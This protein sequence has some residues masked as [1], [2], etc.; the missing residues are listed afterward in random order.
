LVFSEKDL[1][2]KSYCFITVKEN[3]EQQIYVIL[4]RN[5]PAFP[6][7]EMLNLANTKNP[8]KFFNLFFSKWLEK[9]NDI[10][11]YHFR[12]YK[13]NDDTYHFSSFNWDVVNYFY[14]HFNGTPLKKE[15]LSKCLSNKRS[16]KKNFIEENS[17]LI[18]KKPTKNYLDW[19]E[20]LFRDENNSFAT[21]CYSIASY[22][23]EKVHRW[24]SRF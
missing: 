3:D 14:Q 5:F 24:L 18:C 21:N 13:Q 7:N 4:D 22:H 12:K 11:F 10:Y 23:R 1:Y 19:D 2:E 8:S 9:E 6:L 15:Y 17:E 20:D 16:S